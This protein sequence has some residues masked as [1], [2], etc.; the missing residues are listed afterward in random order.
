MEKRSKIIRPQPILILM[1]FIGAACLFA[2]SS[3]LSGSQSTEL[4]GQSNLSIDQNELNTDSVFHQVYSSLQ[5]LNKSESIIKDSGI[6]KSFEVLGEHFRNKGDY[7]LSIENFL[8]ALRFYELISNKSGM[9]DCYTGLGKVFMVQKYYDESLRFYAQAHDINHVLNK[10]TELAS[11]QKDISRVLFYQQEFDKAESFAAKALNMAS[12]I[13][14]SMLIAEVYQVQG[15]IYL[16][17]DQKDK[18]YQLHTKALKFF[19]E[20]SY[21]GESLIFS[22]LSLGT[23]NFKEKRYS[24]AYDY[25]QKAA[26]L[27]GEFNHPSQ[28]A[29]ALYGISEVLAVQNDFKRASDYF[30]QYTAIQDSLTRSDSRRRASEIEILYE[31]E[32]QLAHIDILTGE[33]LIQQAEMKRQTFFLQSLFVFFALVLIVVVILLYN[34]RQKYNTNHLLLKK[35]L[36]I[37]DQKK[38]LEEKN[39]VL[40]EQKEEIHAQNTALEELNKELEKYNQEL[41]MLSVMARETDNAVII[42]DKDGNY[43]WVNEGFSKLFGYG[44]DEL[45]SRGRNLYQASS[46][47]NIQQI[48]SLCLK[49]K[50]SVS[51]ESS[52]VDRNGKIIWLQTTLTPIF[53]EAGQLDKIV[54]I[55]SDVSRLKQVEARL[56]E[57]NWHLERKIEE[58]VQKNRQKD[59]LLAQQSRLAAMGE[60]ISNIAHQWRQPLN[61]IGIIVQNVEDAFAYNEMTPDYLNKKVDKTMELIMFM[62]QTID[63]FRNFFKPDKEKQLF[64]LG[65]IVV[66]ALSFVEASFLKNSIHVEK[67]LD[68]HVLC[69]GYP[70]EYTQVIINLLNN[71]RDA[72]VEN[73]IENPRVCVTLTKMD[74]QSV[75]KIRDNGGGIPASISQR[76]FDPYFTTRNEK[77]GTGLGLYMSKNII[78][79]NMKGRLYFENKEEGVEFSIEV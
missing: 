30:F 31:N 16:A 7:L 68:E 25:F 12:A 49:N 43:E 45:L 63:D 11:N 41:E 73:K 26:T 6:A 28:K 13:N 37:F 36:E 60:M 50:S 54:I 24:L 72:L 46:V 14:D 27:A 59:L 77:S 17:I 33:K 48:I 8:K 15:D 79:K 44:F 69:Q 55:E 35:N 23:Y 57:L 61:A 74:G 52:D 22:Y 70:N 34:N 71:A 67:I 20:L 1:I 66:K 21:K 38:E 39:K 56:S 4:F 9:A 29:Q 42:A 75:L 62:S 18:A 65:D 19:R 53:D 76:I 10:W 5:W 51:Y 58:E 78:E 47:R 40:R 3:R 64:N 32:K 2:S